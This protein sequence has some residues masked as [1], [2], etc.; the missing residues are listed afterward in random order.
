[1][2]SIVF[3]EKFKKIFEKT[4]PYAEMYFL[5]YSWK[6]SHEYDKF[7]LSLGL[8]REKPKLSQSLW[9][10]SNWRRFLCKSNVQFWLSLWVDTVYR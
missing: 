4:D 3:E 5:P 8:S 2:I 7:W 1:M 9:K 10:S 6:K